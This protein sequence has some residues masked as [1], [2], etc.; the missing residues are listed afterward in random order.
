MKLNICVKK[1]QLVFKIF[2]D[3]NLRIRLEST[4]IFRSVKLY[5]LTNNMSL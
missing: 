1:P 3:E 5:I 4:K 2:P